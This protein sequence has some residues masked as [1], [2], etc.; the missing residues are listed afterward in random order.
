MVD[1]ELRGWRDAFQSA[2]EVPAGLKRDVRARS[3]MRRVMLVVMALI[4]LGETA[5]GIAVLLTDDS[6]HGRWMAAFLIG[7]PWAVAL[8]ILRTQRGLWSVS[9]LAPAEVL[10]V[11]QRRVAAGKWLTVFTPVLGVVVA[12]AI[13]A[14][15]FS[16][17][18]S[19]DDRRLTVACAIAQAVFTTVVPL[20]VR[21][22]LND[23]EAVL[24][25]WQAELG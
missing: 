25:R 7:V 5:V 21:R 1:Q 19:S 9:G 6:T 12:I 15:V 17:D 20:V 2:D 8:T 18:A 22:R 11:L 14:L 4:T 23:R 10:K 16:T 13:V 24:A 3:R